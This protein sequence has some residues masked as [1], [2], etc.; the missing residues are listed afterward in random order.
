MEEKK[1]GY[2]FGMV[3]LRP[4]SKFSFVKVFGKENQAV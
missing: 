1:M 4:V 3:K 2:I